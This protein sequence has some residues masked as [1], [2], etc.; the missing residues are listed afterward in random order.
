M[1]STKIDKCGQWTDGLT[2]RRTKRW[3]TSRVAGDKKNDSFENMKV[4]EKKI[5]I[6]ETQRRI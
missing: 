4:R 3:L 5:G 6:T 2:D 1:H